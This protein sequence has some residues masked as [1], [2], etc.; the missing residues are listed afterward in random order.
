VHS[1]EATIT[2]ASSALLQIESLSL[3]QAY[4]VVWMPNE[5]AALVVEPG[6]DIETPRRVKMMRQSSAD[7]DFTTLDSHLE[8]FY[9]N[10]VA[11]HEGDCDIW[12]LA[13]KRE[14]RVEAER[15]ICKSLHG[16]FRH[17]VL[18][19]SATIDR[20]VQ[21]YQGREDIRI[22]RINKVTNELETA[23]L[24]LK[25]LRMTDSEKKALNWAKKGVI[26]TLRY[27]KTDS[28]TKE[29][30]VCIYDGRTKDDPMPDGVKFATQN[31]VKW[32]R[33]FMTTPGCLKT[34]VGHLT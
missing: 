25:V 3:N 2:D 28:K 30:F 9:E 5:L 21:T 10:H 6:G 15:L 14:I 8:V 22:L 26:Q 34:Q 33:Y 7:F 32:R 13:A 17:S 23:I 24:E 31:N 19:R 16:F 20:E 11:T 4:V 29:K 12:H 18:P 1:I 27:S